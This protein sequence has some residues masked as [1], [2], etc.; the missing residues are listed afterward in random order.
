MLDPNKDGCVVFAGNKG[1]KGSLTS[2]DCIVS[3]APNP[4]PVSNK[5]RLLKN[6]KRGFDELWAPYPEYANYRPVRRR[7]SENYFGLDY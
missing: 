5:Y 6:D 3:S 4:A 1:K 2:L 7:T